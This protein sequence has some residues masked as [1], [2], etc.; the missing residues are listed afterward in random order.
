VA[1]TNRNHWLDASR[2]WG[3]TAEARAA[4]VVDGACC[5]EVF[6]FVDASLPAVARGRPG[7]FVARLPWR[8]WSPIADGLLAASPRQPGP[9]ALKS[10]RQQSPANVNLGTHRLRVDDAV[11]LE[12][13][14][15]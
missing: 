6:G 14:A 11:E 15:G 2:G 13:E 1:R 3:A 4:V 10:F 7:R 5:N 8:M 12:V 9:T